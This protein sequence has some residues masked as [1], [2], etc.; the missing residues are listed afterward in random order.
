[1][2]QEYNTTEIGPAKVLDYSEKAIAVQITKEDVIKYSLAGKFKDIG[3]RWN[4]FLKCGPAWIFPKQRE[5]ELKRTI[6]EAIGL[7]VPE[8]EETK[9]KPKFREYFID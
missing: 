9:P 3:G 2:T 1:M 6:A 8:F 4:Q 5:K 7:T